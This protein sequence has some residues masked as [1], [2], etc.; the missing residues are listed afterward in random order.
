MAFQGRGGHWSLVDRL[1]GRKQQRPQNTG[2]RFARSSLAD[3]AGPTGPGRQ[4][5]SKLA[6]TT[7]L[8]AQERGLAIAEIDIMD[9]E[10]AGGRTGTGRFSSARSGERERGGGESPKTPMGSVPWGDNRPGEGRIRRPS[11]V[12]GRKVCHQK[13]TT[14]PPGGG[15]SVN[16]AKARKGLQR[17]R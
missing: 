3:R 5:H 13:N 10:L 7:K 8:R 9:R 14:Y 6:R 17:W 12:D 1:V 11:R 15:Q 16:D 4:K 2:L